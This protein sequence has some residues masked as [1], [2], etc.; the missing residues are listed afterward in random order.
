MV[1]IN[2]IKNKLKREELYQKQKNAK[3]KAKRDR[4]TVLQKEESSNPEKK[5]KR[6]TEN[7]PNTLENTREFDETIVEDDAEVAADEET[8]EFAQ[9]FQNGLAPKIL[10]T[11]S[12]GP[13]ASV[14][15][16]ATELVD[17]FPNTHFVKRKA[18]FEMRHIIEFSKNR[19]FTD[20]MVIN[21]DRKEPNALTLIHLPN[22]PTAHFK[23]SSIALSKD[24][25]GHGRTSSHKPELILN[26]FNTR[27]GHTIGR[28]F[29]AL[30]P[31]VP[32][33]QGRQVATL[34][35]QRDFIFF[36]RHRYMFKNAK[37][38]NLQELGPRFT[39]KLKWLQKGTFDRKGE[40][41]WMFKPEMET[42]RRR[43][44]L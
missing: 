16:F 20:I 12:K 34:H 35:N 5:E 30:F 40:H 23:L 33:F 41:E 6:L 29:T 17:I 38:V 37:R 10:I 1:E 44:F 15:E 32:E 43:F 3:A 27:L 4:R 19:D 31:H 42:S 21:E 18:Q 7:V 25:E 22:G 13:S 36:R 28:M 26:N 9:Y 14:Y 39:L 8:D 11:T 2:T 24:I